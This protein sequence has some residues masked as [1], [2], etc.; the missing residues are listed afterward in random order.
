DLLD[1][2]LVKFYAPRLER[3]FAFAD[4]HGAVT[5]YGRK[6]GRKLRRVFNRRQ[7]FKRK[8]QRILSNILGVLAPNYSSRSAYYRCA[9]ARCEFIECVQVAQYR[10][11]YQY[12][13]WR[14]YACIRHLRPRALPQ[15]FFTLHD[16]RDSRE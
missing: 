7:R 1:Q 8:Q 12:F 14:F 2:K 4:A 11:D 3:A 10:R 5:G 15:D 6:P 9:I 16:Y 13:I